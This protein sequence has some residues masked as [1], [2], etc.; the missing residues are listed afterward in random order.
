MKTQL[1]SKMSETLRER[2]PLQISKQEA[3]S[4]LEFNF[5]ASDASE[6]NKA[7]ELTFKK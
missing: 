3:T 4:Y 2:F 5:P 7:F 6:R 1:I